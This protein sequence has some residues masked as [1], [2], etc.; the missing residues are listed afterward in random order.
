MYRAF[1]S[2]AAAV[3]LIP[4]ASPAQGARFLW[5][6]GQ[7][8][9]YQVEHLSS[10]AEV[11]DAT[12]TESKTRMNLTKRWQ[13]IELDKD[14]VATMQLSLTAMRW[15]TTTPSGS[16]LLFD[17]ADPAKSDE[18]LREELGRLVGHT[19]AVLRVDA[20]GKVVEV[21][22]AKHGPASRYES[23]LPFVV[24]LP[25]A[26]LQPGQTWQRAYK[27]T[28]DPPQGTGDKYDAVQSYLCKGTNEATATIALV[29]ELKNQPESLFDRIPLLQMQP[30]GEVVFDVRAG[31]LQSAH[32]RIDKQLAGHQGEGSSYRFQSSYSEDLVEAK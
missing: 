16:T 19:L 24:V 5:Q 9:T 3:L 2:T 17:S 13:V 30:E 7:V 23:E 10:V 15:E 1:L 11:I 21:K 22:E 25:D 6:Q 8:L 4:A 14:G 26:I 29:T 18:H 27:I 28:L 31:R 12:K 20:Q 32:L